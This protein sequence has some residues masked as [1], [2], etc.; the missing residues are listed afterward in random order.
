MNDNPYAAPHAAVAEAPEP[1]VPEEIAKQIRSAWIAAVVSGTLT[2]GF[3]L[4]AMSGNSMA[5][6]TAW[7]LVDVGL[8]FALAWGIYRNSRASAVA[9]LVYFIV[10]KILIMIEVGKPTGIVLSLIFI[11]YFY[12]GV[13]G[14]FAYRK[15]VRGSA[16]AGAAA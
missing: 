5:G 12:R 2:L 14:T 3:T 10:S 8:I 13:Q 16:N 15:F 7:N 1:R 4:L 9:M 6:I 11:Y